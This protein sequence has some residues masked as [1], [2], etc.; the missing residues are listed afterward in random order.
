MNI[1]LVFPASGQK[2]LTDHNYPLYSALS[3][4]VPQFHEAASGLRFASIGGE[5]DDDGHLRLTDR[6]CLRVRVADDAI[7]TVLP[8]AGKRLEIAG[9]AVR[10]GVP[11]VRTLIPAP[12][13]FAR[14]VTFKNNDTP[15]DFLE[16][17]REKLAEMGVTAEPELP[18]HITGDRAGEP[19][20]KIVRIK[21]VAIVGYS[22]L[23][24]ELSADDSLKLQT[25]G[26]GGRTQMGC[27]FF[28]PVKEGQQ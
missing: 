3:A 11:A 1:E 15:K 22:L 2:I 18:I 16:T 7:R 5:P 26:L 21:G 19:H 23:V 20:R 24:S 10:L 28:V 27:G 9:H 8:L 6:S 12:R 17:A 14:I 4:V 25:H 13:L